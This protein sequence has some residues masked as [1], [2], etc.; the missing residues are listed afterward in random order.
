MPLP[1]RCFVEKERKN[2]LSLIVFMN[3]EAGMFIM[4]LTGSKVSQ[5]SSLH[6]QLPASQGRS[7]STRGGAAAARMTAAE[8]IYCVQQAI[9]Y[10]DSLQLGRGNLQLTRAGFEKWLSQLRLVHD[11]S[12][13]HSTV[14][15]VVR[16]NS[17]SLPVITA[18][19]RS[20]DLMPLD[21]GVFGTAKSS[22]MREVSQMATWDTRAERFVKLLGE[23]KFKP[24]IEAYHKRLKM[25]VDRDGRRVE[26]VPK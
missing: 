19:P 1:E 22:L 25:C 9:K 12:S 20:P 4:P 18:P 17:A 5:H 24:I 15:I 26:G 13:C 3:M 7:Y 10:Y 16:G 14:D 11:R 8:Y 2:S 21:Y 23:T 6:A